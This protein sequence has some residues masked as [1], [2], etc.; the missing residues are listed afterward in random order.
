M[1]ENFEAPKKPEKATKRNVNKGNPPSFKEALRQHEKDLVKNIQKNVD[2]IRQ[3]F[4]IK[5]TFAE[6]EKAEGQRTLEIPA[7]EKRW[8]MTHYLL[9]EM[10]KLPKSVWAKFQLKAI[11]ISGGVGRDMFG[12]ESA[13]WMQSDGIL[14]LGFGYPLYHEL[15]HRVDRLLG[16]DSFTNN[17][18]NVWFMEREGNV[19]NEYYRQ[20][21]AHVTRAEIRDSKWRELCK[22]DGESTEGWANETFNEDRANTAAAL[23]DD[24]PDNRAE[25]EDSDKTPARAAQI[26][27][28]LEEWSG[29]LLDKQYWT[30]LKAGKVDESYWEK[31]LKNQK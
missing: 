5:V 17:D 24:A 14:E 19:Q 7:L 31:R 20:L 21:K 11:M 25:W 27:K 18:A 3:K 13:G 10:G 29:G 26:K 28:E 15:F 23:F 16:Q 2:T 9:M 1:P 30:Y 4:G 12:Q 22:L 6:S 8:E